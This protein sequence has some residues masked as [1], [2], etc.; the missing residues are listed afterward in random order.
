ML[1]FANY[2]HFNKKAETLLLFFTLNLDKI[3][4]KLCNKEVNGKH[5]YPTYNSLALT[6]VLQKIKQQNSDNY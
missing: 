5:V 2:A 6:T 3:P 4:W 1:V